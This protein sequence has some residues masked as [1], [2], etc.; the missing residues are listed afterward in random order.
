MCPGYGREYYGVPAFISRQRS[1]GI[2]PDWPP[3][4]RERPAPELRCEREWACGLVRA[5]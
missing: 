1:W 5:R 2:S 3:P 4:A